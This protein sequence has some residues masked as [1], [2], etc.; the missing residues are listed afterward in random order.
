MN[1]IELIEQAAS[2]IKTRKTDSGLFADVG[3]A[4]LAENQK[5][6]LGVCAD[7]GSNVFCA[8]TNAIGSMITEGVYRIKKI[9]AVW[10]DEGDQTF[11]IS[12]CGNC[13][14]LIY[15]IH[16]D[17]LKTDII[18]DREKTMTLEE[19]LPLSRW[20]KKQVFC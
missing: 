13:R 9:V 7:S 4:L 6:Y 18:L 12:P 19:L 17:N 15:E 10:K 3:C 5:V 2:I 14:Q 11:V 1:N 16:S 20:W 8:E